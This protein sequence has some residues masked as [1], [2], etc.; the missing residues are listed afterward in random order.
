[1]K[2]HLHVSPFNLLMSSAASHIG[3]VL[4]REAHI[5]DQAQPGQPDQKA[6]HAMQG[7][8]YPRQQQPAPA[9]RRQLRS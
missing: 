7:C 8:A 9:V 3:T 1:M 4:R 6:S 5:C 2:A